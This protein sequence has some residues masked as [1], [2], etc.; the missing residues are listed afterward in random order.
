[1]IEKIEEIIKK[2]Q[3][4]DCFTV[5]NLGWNLVAQRVSSQEPIQ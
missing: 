2:K 3:G 4:I 1:M 5:S